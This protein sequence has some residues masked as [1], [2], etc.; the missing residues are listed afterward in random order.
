MPQKQYDQGNKD[1]I[2]S[3]DFLKGVDNTESE[4]SSLNE[5]IYFDSVSFLLAGCKGT[6]TGQRKKD[7]MEREKCFVFLGGREGNDSQTSVRR[8]MFE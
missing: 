4:A 6:L 8:Q 5:L 1:T 3:D 7:W 2:L